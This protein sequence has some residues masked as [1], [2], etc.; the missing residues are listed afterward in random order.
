MFRRRR[1]DDEAFLER[2][3]A[4]L[5]GRPPD[6]EGRRTYVEAMARGMSHGEVALA[7]AASP[8]HRARATRGRGVRVD[9]N[10]RLPDLTTE[11]P[12]RYEDG[13]DLL[14]REILTFDGR[15]DSDFDW[16]ERRIAETGYYDNDGVWQLDID[17]DKRLAAEL[18]AAFAPRRVVELGCSSGA[19]LAC[20]H[21]RGIEVTGIDVSEHA[22]ARAQP[23]VR[24]RIV[25]GDLLTLDI[26]GGHD[27]ALGLDVFEH[28]NPNRIDAYLARLASLV[29][30]GGWCITNIPV[31]GDDPV[32]GNVFV[33]YLEPPLPKTLFRRVHVDDRG[34]PLHGHLIWATWDWWVDRF[35]AV[36]LQRRPDVERAVHAR[37][38]AHWA[39]NSPARQTMYVFAKGDAADAPVVLDVLSEP[40]PLLA[41]HRAAT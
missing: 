6:D 40:S 31:Y 22:R 1:R 33:D 19:V 39:V 30:D 20:L 2:A 36:G 28:L 38:G 16:L 14:G 24:D 26:D 3:Y 37:Y 29:R 8:E 11:R 4:E 35:E 18:V 12:D 5:L 13:L 25:L 23:A 34:Y 32:F 9:G 7:I 41:Q 15:D 21:E 10:P 17:L 27:V